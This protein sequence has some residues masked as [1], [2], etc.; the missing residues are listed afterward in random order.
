MVPLTGAA[1]VAFLLFKTHGPHTLPIDNTK[2][3]SVLIDLDG[4]ISMHMG[5]P[6]TL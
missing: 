6:L 1:V 4:M 3:P 2:K 5:M